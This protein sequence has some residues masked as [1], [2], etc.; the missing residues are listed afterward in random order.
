MVETA[1]GIVVYMFVVFG[2]IDLTLAGFKLAAVRYVAQ[3][4]ARFTSLGEDATTNLTYTALDIQNRAIE[5]S[6]KFGFNID[7]VY[8]LK[9]CPLTQ[10][11]ASCIYGDAATSTPASLVVPASFVPFAV[12]VRAKHNLFHLPIFPLTLSS[13]ALARVEP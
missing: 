4:V 5:T 1:L 2:L 11:V 9:V 13:S 6:Q 8:D 12:E 3:D 7:A 10:S